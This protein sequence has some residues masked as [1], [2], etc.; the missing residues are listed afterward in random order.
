MGKVHVC[1][2]CGAPVLQMDIMVTAEQDSNGDWQLVVPGQDA[3]NEECTEPHTQVR[4]G[5]M[6]CGPAYHPAWPE[7]IHAENKFQWWKENIALPNGY[8]P[9]E[10]NLDPEWA[11]FAAELGHMPWEGTMGQTNTLE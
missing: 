10:E 8:E 7:P 3:I 6:F 5:N 1:P 11:K 9:E 2:V 4:C